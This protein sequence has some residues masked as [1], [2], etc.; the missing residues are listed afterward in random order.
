MLKKITFS[1][2]TLFFIF[3]A[4]LTID[5]LLS[6]GD[7]GVN[8][9]LFV[10][11]TLH[12]EYLRVNDDLGRIFF[13]GQKIKPHMAGDLMRRDKKASS[14]RI[15]VFGGSSAAGWPYY[16]NGTFA[17]MLQRQLEHSLPAREIEVVNF[18]MPAINSRAIRYLVKKSL[19]WQPDA[20]LVYA[21]HNEYYGSL[22]AA[23]SVRLSPSLVD[24]YLRLSEW[25]LFQLAVTLIKGGEQT[26]APQ[27]G[28]TLMQRMVGQQKIPYGS[29]LYRKGLKDFSENLREIAAACRSASVP[30]F[31]SDLAANLSDQPPFISDEQSPYPAGEWYL[32][33]QQWRRDGEHLKARRAFSRARDYDLLRFRAAD[34][35]NRIIHE[36][37]GDEGYYLVPGEGAVAAMDA[38]GYIGDKAMLDHLHPNLEATRRISAAFYRALIKSKL[39]R[40]ADTLFSISREKLGITALDDAIG[41]LRINILKA[42]WPFRIP[43]RLDSFLAAYKPPTVLEQLAW[44]Y[45]NGK[46][47]WHDAHYN[48]TQMYS[49]RE[50]WPAAAEEY[51]ALLYDVGLDHRLM[52]KLA[53]ALLQTGGRDEALQWLQ[54]S[55]RIRD[56]YQARAMMGLIYTHRLEF[57]EAIKQFEA[58]LKFRPADKSTLY[59]LAGL[60]RQVGDMDKSREIIQRM[61]KDGGAAN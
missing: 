17:R 4:L 14:L 8:T 43:S 37:A 33:G 3:I 56:G 45:W 55:V 2:V 58:A 50:S 16:Y 21:G 1:L 29:L 23:S 18:S 36:Q 60:Y 46:L 30:L 59:N 22:G 52:I 54:K 31:I 7:V 49:S 38:H 34:T 9:D 44:E 47:S 20:I 40:P 42:G 53:A 27:K 24:I 5:T 10:E 32:K 51:R 35:L 13:P 61:K 48:L 12:A 19:R 41:R 25:R 11:D 57:K 39:I 6:W 28:G 26:A 15:F